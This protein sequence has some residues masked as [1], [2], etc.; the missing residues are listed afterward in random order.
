MGKKVIRVLLA[1]AGLD[2]HDR[3]VRLIA[4]GLK[5]RGMEI[6]YTG[7]YRTEEEIVE[8]ALQEDVD[9]IG[10]SVH[11]GSHHKLFT[12][13]HELLDARD[14]RD[15]LVI[16]G[17]FIPEQHGKELKDSGL[18]AEVFGPGTSVNAVVDWI[19]DAIAARRE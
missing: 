6:V 1:K 11:T 16:G 18:V 12:R 9:I 3:G 15:I 19:H 7:L 17:G 13:I 8:T 4:R 2:T 10:L 5:D 14:A